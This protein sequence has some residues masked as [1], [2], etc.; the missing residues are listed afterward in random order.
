M[1][2]SIHADKESLSSKCGILESC[3]IVHEVGLLKLIIY[4]Y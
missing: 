4:I 1:I 3:T 2:K